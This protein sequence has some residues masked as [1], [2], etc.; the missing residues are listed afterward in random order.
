MSAGEGEFCPVLAA[1]E[2]LQE[3]WVL[4]IVKALLDGPRGF[5]ELGRLTGGCNSATLSSR[6]EHLVELGLVSKHVESYMPPR[7][8]YSLT[9]AGQAL[10]RVIDAIAEWGRT[11]LQPPDAGDG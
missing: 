5:N 6:L 8:L 1:M 10:Q 4:H 11:Y 3:K 7:T 9:P 2:I